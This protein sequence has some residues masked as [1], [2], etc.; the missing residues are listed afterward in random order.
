[1]I[2]VIAIIERTR[3][4]SRGLL[5]LRDRDYEEKV[6]PVIKILFMIFGF[7]EKNLDIKPKTIDGIQGKTLRW[8]EATKEYTERMG[9]GMLSM[10]GVLTKYLS[11]GVTPL[12]HS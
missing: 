10:V 12:P 3:R 1:M 6:I 9:Q 5:L 8:V 7:L 2:E 11:K 4:S